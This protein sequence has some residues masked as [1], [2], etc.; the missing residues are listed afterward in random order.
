MVRKRLEDLQHRAKEV[1]GALVGRWTRRVSTAEKRIL[2]RRTKEAEEQRK[3]LASIVEEMRAPP[4]LVSRTAERAILEATK[5]DVAAGR[6]TLKVLSE[7]I[8]PV[9][10]WPVE[11]RAQLDS[12]RGWAYQ[13]AKE[14]ERILQKLG[15]TVTAVEGM[16][17]GG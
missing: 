8:T 12:L 14:T 11:V 10:Q 15:A 2:E 4:E 6:E 3:M 16:G 13:R 7:M 9:L 5:Q 1:A 17:G